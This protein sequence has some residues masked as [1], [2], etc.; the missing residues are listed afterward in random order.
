M[1]D[2]PLCEYRRK[3][4]SGD[5]VHEAIENFLETLTMDDRYMSAFEL[6]MK[7]FWTHKQDVKVSLH[8]QKQCTV[9][10]LQNKI[11]T[12]VK[13]CMTATSPTLIACY[14]KEIITLEDERR[15]C[16][17]E[18]TAATDEIQEDDFMHHFDRLKAVIQSPV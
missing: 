11:D 6:I 17:A 8:S 12:L 3:S 10:E 5:K 18:L 15:L 16:E 4:I 13:K 1:C 2:N 7:Y 9:A 14:E